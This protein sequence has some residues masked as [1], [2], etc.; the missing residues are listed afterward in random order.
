MAGC[1][2]PLAKYAVASLRLPE[3]SMMILA[4]SEETG[5]AL[6]VCEDGGDRRPV[7]REHPADSCL[8][9]ERS[10]A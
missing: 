5:T 9:F 2:M 10:C 6:F 3:P 8:S 7:R 1:G 4:S